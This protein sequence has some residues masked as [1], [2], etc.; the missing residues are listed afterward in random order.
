MI[1]HRQTLHCCTTSV[2]GTMH[3]NHT[4]QNADHGCPT[5][6]WETWLLVQCRGWMPCVVKRITLVMGQLARFFACFGR[7]HRKCSNSFV[8]L[9]VTHNNLA[10][11]LFLQ[12]TT[13]RPCLK[14]NINKGTHCL[15]IIHKPRQTSYCSFP[16]YLGPPS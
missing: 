6:A 2:F 9:Q 4:V 8:D 16:P 5:A 7:H 1:L 10:H 14:C 12:V 13:L 15:V 11:L 3:A